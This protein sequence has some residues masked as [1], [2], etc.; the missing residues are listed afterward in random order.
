RNLW[1]RHER[2]GGVDHRCRWN[3]GEPSAEAGGPEPL[4]TRAYPL[5]DLGTI[6]GDPLRA[7]GGR[8]ESAG[9]VRDRRCCTARGQRGLI[10]GSRL[11]RRPCRGA[12]YVAVAVDDGA[13]AAGLRA[14]YAGGVGRRICLLSAARTR[15]SRGDAD[16]P[17]D[18]RP[19]S[20]GPRAA[21]HVAVAVDD[22]T[23]AAGLGAS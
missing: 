15:G 11:A 17:R 22:R 20:D 19:R 3:T 10:L 4:G 9:A 14:A 2:F 6:A 8:L 13:P 16:G 7:E 1:V 21:A 18:D 5:G 23:G 12:A